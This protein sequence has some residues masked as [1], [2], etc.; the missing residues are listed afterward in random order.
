MIRNSF[1]E[2]DLNAIIIIIFFLFVFFFF[3]GGGGGGGGGGGSWSRYCPKI[4]K[5]NS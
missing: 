5:K 3:S 4:L 2:Y 1:L